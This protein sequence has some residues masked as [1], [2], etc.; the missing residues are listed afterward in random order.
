M[1]TKS[2][3]LSSQIHDDIEALRTDLTKIMKTVSSMASNGAD[4]AFSQVRRGAEKTKA[5]AQMAA[6]V[7]T[8]Q[9][10]KKPIASALIALGMGMMIGVMLRRK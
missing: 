7:L 8:H 5:Q 6:D 4:A 3:D 1:A 10:E 2:D 9:I